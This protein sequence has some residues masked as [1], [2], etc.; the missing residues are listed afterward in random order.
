MHMFT[1]LDI[2]MDVPVLVPNDLDS[3]EDTHNRIKEEN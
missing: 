2:W 3:R 1:D